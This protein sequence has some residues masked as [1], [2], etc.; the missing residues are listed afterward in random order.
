MDQVTVVLRLQDSS[1]VGMQNKQH[2]TGGKSF[3]NPPAYTLLGSLPSYLRLYLTQP[4]LEL[5]SER[6]KIPLP[7]E[8]GCSVLPVLEK[9]PL[10]VLENNLQKLPELYS[11]LDFAAL[12]S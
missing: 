4:F 6:G 1:Y 5:L 11:E 12:I 3:P 7:Y 9:A 8:E 2:Q 10:N